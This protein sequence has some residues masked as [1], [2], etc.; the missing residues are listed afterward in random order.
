V[1]VIIT[2]GAGFIGSYLC[3]ELSKDYDVV[4]IDS[5]FNGTTL[6]HHDNVEY[7]NL[8]TKNISTLDIKPDVIIHLG[9]Y[10]RVEQSFKDIKLVHDY[11]IDGTFQVLEYAKKHKARV[12]Y[13][14]T[15][16]LFSSSNL[17]PYTLFKKQN[18]DLIKAYNK[19]Y[20]LDYS[21]CHFYNVY[22]YNN[23]KIN[24][25][26]DIISLYMN[27]YSNNEPLKV[28]GTG[29]QK[30]NFTHVL[31]TVQGIKL[32]LEKGYRKHYMIGHPDA[33]S[34]LEVAKMFSNRIEFIPDREGNRKKSFI[35]PESIKR[36]GLTYKYN[37]EDFIEDFKNTQKSK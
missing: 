12:I 7:I 13:A 32:V 4:S 18:I 16:S 15:S 8:N 33:Y 17:S 25:Y 23:Q 36:L 34:V 31:D 22:G 2:G 14:S 11:N 9:E 26:S 5:Y 29:L 28:T 10:S 27:M 3:K 24:K 30:R 6:N 20:N 37:I 21:I 1:T 35:N 19:W